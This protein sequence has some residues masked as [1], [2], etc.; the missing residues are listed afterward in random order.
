MATLTQFHCPELVTKQLAFNKTDKTPRK[1]RVSSNF[2]ALMGYEHNDRLEVVKSPDRFGGFSVVKADKGTHKVHA[3]AYKSGRANNPCETV[4]EFGSQTLIDNAFAPSINRFHTQI[5][6]DKII[7]SPLINRAAAIINK[8]KKESPL[9]AFVALT[10]GVDTY[11][12]E[13]LG[14]DVDVALEY[15]PQERRDTTDKSEVNLLNNARNATPNILLNEDI[16]NVELDQLEKVLAD[17]P[18]IGLAHYSIQCDCFSNLK[19]SADKAS[20]IEDLSTTIDMFIPML[21]QIKIIQPAAIVV[22]NVIGFGRSQA[23]AICM[24]QLRR[25]GYHVTALEMD[26]RDYGGIQT[27]KRFYLVASIM[28]G[29]V[30]PSKTERNTLPIWPRIQEFLPECRDVSHTNFI[31][32]RAGS[33]RATPSITESSVECPT[34]VKSQSRG[35]KDGTYIQTEDGRILAPSEAVV[36]RLMSI[37]D[38]FDTSWMGSESAI[39]VLGQSIDYAMHETLMSSVKDHLQVGF[40]GARTV[41]N[42]RQRERLSN[43]SNATPDQLTPK[44]MPKSARSAENQLGFGF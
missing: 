42:F 44:V 17:R 41:V 38:A 31:K 26:A 4:I 36:K 30:A 27:R 35:I 22:E 25:L 37:P 34:I 14:F 13:S 20:S 3:R 11:C 32:N 40:G 29:F 21:E 39:E 19:N 9:K 15:R 43:R 6:K 7:F 18:P 2:L 16:Y 10:G 28:P 24:T 5:T 12:L 23:G 33:N 8:F 1:L